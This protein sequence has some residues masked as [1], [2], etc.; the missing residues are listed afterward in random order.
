MYQYVYEL[1]FF[2]SRSRSHHLYLCQLF[3]LALIIARVIYSVNEMTKR[4]IYQLN[5]W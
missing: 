5:I 4:L 2:R 3:H 1:F